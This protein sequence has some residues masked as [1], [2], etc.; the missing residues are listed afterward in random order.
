VNLSDALD[1]YK[2]ALDEATFIEV[3]RQDSWVDAY[4]RHADGRP[5]GQTEAAIRAEVSSLDAER[6]RCENNVRA[7]RAEL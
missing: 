3:Q 1:Q 2:A 4:R 5:W 7:A 6:T